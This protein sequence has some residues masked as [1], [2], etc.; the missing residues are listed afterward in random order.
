MNRKHVSKM[1]KYIGMACLLFV[2][3][4]VQSC[5]DEYF[6]DDR[7]P[8][9]LGSSIY[10]YLQEQGN[11]TYFLKVIDDLGYAEVLRKTG[12]KTLFVA[13]DEA[14]MKGIKERWGVESYGGLSYAQ[15]RIIL[16]G[17]ML[18]NAYLLEML[19]KKQSDGANGEPVPGSILRRA[20]DLSVA[21]FVGAYTGKDIPQVNEDWDAF[22]DDTI[23]M[24]LDA[25]KTL[26][27][28]LVNDY[29]YMN[30]VSDAD[31][32][33]L[34]G[35]PTASSS[36]IYIYD[37]KVV[38]EKSDVTC[39]NGYVH[40]LDGLLIPPS[41]MAEELRLN[42]DTAMYRTGVWDCDALAANESSTMLFSRMLDRYSVPVPL[43]PESD[44]VREYQRI[45]GENEQVTLF[46]KRY[47]T[48][49]SNRGATGGGFTSYTTFEDSVRN[50]AGSLE[51]DPGWNAYK[52]AA[53]NSSSETD[54][55][56]IFAP[57]DKA[58][59]DY[60]T[61]Q[62]EGKLLIERYA[63]SVA[64]K[65]GKGLVEAL[66]SIPVEILQPLVRNL[67]QVSFVS[68]VPSKFDLITDDA[69]DPM[70]VSLDDVHH[71]IVANN[72]VVYV[73]K[74]LY[75]PSTYKSVFAPVML[76]ANFTIFDDLVQQTKAN[77]YRNYLLSMNNKFSLVV[78]DDA[79]MVY[80]S[81]YNDIKEAANA[82]NA[83]RFELLPGGTYEVNAYKYDD[84]SYDPNTN[85]YVLADKPGTD[86]TQAVIDE[87][88]KEILEYNIVIGDMNSEADCESGRKYYMSKGYGMVMVQRGSNGKVSAIAGGRERQHGAWIPVAENDAKGMKNGHAF[89]LRTS[90]IQPP[91]QNVYDVLGK[92]GSAFADL[93]AGSDEKNAV[94]KKILGDKYDSEKKRYEIFNSGQNNIV[95]FFNTYHYTV[96]VPTDEAVTEAIAQGLP[97]WESLNEEL[98]VLESTQDA[99]RQKTLTDSLKAGAELLTKFIKYHFQDNAVFVDRPRHSVEI[100]GEEPKYVVEYTTA[101]SVVNDSTSRFCEVSVKSENYVGKDGSVGEQTIAVRGDFRKEH[102][103]DF[104]DEN[105]C[106]VNN[107]VAEQE[108]LV[109]NVL[110][111]DIQFSGKNVGTSSYAVV[112][113][114]NDCLK[115]G[116][117]GG[118]YDLEKKQ[119][120]R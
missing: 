118:I 114:I 21:D 29:L 92:C 17:A 55:A 19:S 7:E 102:K 95:R 113:Q 110:T 51:F 101:A 62:D 117:E 64:D 2:C 86:P 20:T 48:E 47:Y 37:K 18:D 50:A 57:S 98:K 44:A 105:V 88:K 46:E 80:Y 68:C 82:R 13:D 38:R 63:E 85:R 12:S 87:L 1:G 99:E 8:D 52:Q 66:D 40:Q 28:H 67:M 96:Y 5:R 103:G 71:T 61:T 24:A 4:M 22:R 70:G 15:K 119:F 100:Q 116:G 49:G 112:H 73:M 90:M 43:D 60:F 31:L 36:D 115:F 25:T 42:H 11:F 41:N 26:L 39:K 45:Y 30:N 3:A 79:N 120:I 97:T 74:K 106:Y 53:A 65:F 58:V 59:V 23:Y 54:M 35:D 33:V 72:G 84:A 9:F 69:K 34:V 91:T 6:Y 108:N 32:Q 27:L 56:A 78:T 107:T 83:Y 109:Y 14:F 76:D 93:C 10:D 89:K 75:S 16:Y 94:L 81:P 77:A 104:G 111:R